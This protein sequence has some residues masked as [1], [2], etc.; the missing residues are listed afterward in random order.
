[1]SIGKPLSLPE[2][3]WL[4]ILH[5]VRFPVNYLGYYLD[6][7]CDNLQAQKDALSLAATSRALRKVL[8]P[9]LWKHIH[10]TIFKSDGTNEENLPKGY[11]L[12]S[13]PQLSGSV[14]NSPFLNCFW[15]GKGYADYDGIKENYFDNNYMPLPRKQLGSID[16]FLIYVK[17]FKISNNFFHDGGN[18]CYKESRDKHTLA[19]H[20]VHPK[21]MPLLMDLEIEICMYDLSAYE[22]LASVLGTFEQKIR[23][24]L[25]VSKWFVTKVNQGSFDLYIRHAHV[26]TLPLVVDI[27]LL[28]PTDYNVNTQNSSYVRRLGDIR[29]NVTIVG[30]YPSVVSYLDVTQVN[31]AL[32]GTFDWF[33]STVKVLKCGMNFLV[34]P[35]NEEHQYEVFDNVNSLTLD[36][37][38]DEGSL[39][40]PLDNEH[41]SVYFHNLTE[42]H[43]TRNRP[44]KGIPQLIYFTVVGRLLQSNRLNLVSLGIEYIYLPEFELISDHFTSIK[45]LEYDLV[46]PSDDKETNQAKFISN[47]MKNW[48]SDLQQ[49]SYKISTVKLERPRL[50]SNIY[51]DYD[52]FRSQV[53]DHPSLQFNAVQFMNI[54]AAETV[55]TKASN[56]FGSTFEKSSDSEHFM[57]K[58]FCDYADPSLFAT[59]EVWPRDLSLPSRAKDLTPPITRVFIDL[60]KLR[61]LISRVELSESD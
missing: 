52:D 55:K 11:S 57:L 59:E 22:T 43:L 20:L 10:L 19:I 2:D 61:A 58:D 6:P 34:T 17:A 29:S 13:N 47:M 35:E 36:L 16:S 25:A 45:N 32:P 39:D 53:L 3:I 44:K 5:Q 51:I 48:S 54:L 23:L 30:C 24:K 56:I 46:F 26:T 15:R 38:W 40:L 27:I 33:H 12:F 4:E 1:M 49:L 60:V 42:L 7:V 37:Q 21:I 18:L 31:S 8:A 14:W 28:T 41:Y 50:E 9:K